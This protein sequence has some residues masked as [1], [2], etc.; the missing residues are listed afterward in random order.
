MKGEIEAD[1]TT[2]EQFIPGK[3]EKR[4]MMWETCETIGET[5]GYPRC[6]QSN[7]STARLISDLVTCVSQDGNLLLNVGPSPRG[8]IKP[9]FVERLTQI[10]EWLDLNGESVYG[11]K[12]AEKSWCNLGCPQRTFAYTRKDGNLYLHF[13]DRYPSY[14]L[15]LNPAIDPALIEYAELLRDGTDIPVDFIVIDGKKH[16]RLCLPMINPDPY[17]TVV[18]IVMKKTS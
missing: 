2:P 4:E 10:G 11:A 3:E 12:A 1:F 8:E 15:V 6:D 18:K 13:F 17:D 14:D 7:K 9:E 5:W 16:A